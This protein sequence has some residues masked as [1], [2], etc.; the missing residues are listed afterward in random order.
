MCQA[1]TALAMITELELEPEPE[2]ERASSR[3][4]D[5]RADASTRPGRVCRDEIRGGSKRAS[6]RTVQ[7]R[8]TGERRLTMKRSPRCEMKTSLQWEQRRAGRS[9]TNSEGQYLC[10]EPGRL[11]MQLH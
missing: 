1:A 10:P 5:S 9:D 11:L 8:T 3:G 7:S 2:L 6:D 4:D